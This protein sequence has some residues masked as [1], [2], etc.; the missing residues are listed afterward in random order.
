MSLIHQF[1]KIEHVN[2]FS[3]TRL[4]HIGKGGFYTFHYSGRGDTEHF[5]FYGSYNIK[6]LDP[7]EIKT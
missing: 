3:A 2:Q 4:Q 5:V 1:T 7:K 6:K